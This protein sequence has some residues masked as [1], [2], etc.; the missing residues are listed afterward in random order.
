VKQ[1]VEKHSGH[2][3]VTSEPGKGSVFSFTLPKQEIIDKIR[4]GQ[5]EE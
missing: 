1:V 2:V 5:A 3:S 4:G